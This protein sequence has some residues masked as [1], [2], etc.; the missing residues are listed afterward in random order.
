MAL[1]SKCRLLQSLACLSHV[2]P[3]DQTWDPSDEHQ[4][5][6]WAVF[7]LLCFSSLSLKILVLFCLPPK[8]G[9]LL[10]SWYYAFFHHAS[11]SSCVFGRMFCLFVVPCAYLVLQQ[12][13]VSP[14]YSYTHCLPLWWAN[15]SRIYVPSRHY[16]VLIHCWLHYFTILIFRIKVS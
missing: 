12:I 9:G 5:A 16:E 10:F 15:C 6:K 3:C 11:H 4:S 8:R 13:F 2:G 1:Y 14:T 7:F